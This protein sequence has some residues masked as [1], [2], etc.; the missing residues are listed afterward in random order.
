MNCEALVHFRCVHE[1]R[2]PG[3]IQNPARQFR[4]TRSRSC[5]SKS[6]SHCWR[7]S[8]R[9]G[10]MAR[11]QSRHTS[12]TS[13]DEGSEHELAAMRPLP[14]LSYGKFHV[15]LHCHVRY[16]SV[17]SVHPALARPVSALARYLASTRR[18]LLGRD[19]S[20]LRSRNPARA[21]ATR[22]MSRMSMSAN[23]SRWPSE[24]VASSIFVSL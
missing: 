1:R 5:T 17:A 13:I 12:P 19:L 23:I 11:G 16:H 6:E 18:S 9:P 3:E 7:V 8:T 14:G 22:F 2:A 15:R 10:A 24:G 4:S 21:C 20:M